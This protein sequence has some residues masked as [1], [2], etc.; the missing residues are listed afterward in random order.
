MTLALHPLVLLAAEE[1]GKAAEES[2]RFG[3]IVWGMPAV[4]WHFINFVIFL[5]IIYFAAKGIVVAGAQAKRDKIVREIEESSKLRDEMRAKFQDYDARM[6]DIDAR[7]NALLT[8][9]RNE[10][11]SEK[12]RMLGEAE[13]AAKRM[14][15]EA[16]LI[17]DQEIARARIELREEQIARAGELAEQILRTSVTKDDQNRLSQEFLAE[18]GGKTNGRPA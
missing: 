6:K 3:P 12:K 1:A 8:D 17:A 9:A 5:G 11:E 2:G 14:R 10:A 18:M 15:D 4:V 16:K 13:A 7:M